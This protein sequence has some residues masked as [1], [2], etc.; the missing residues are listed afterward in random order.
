MS[1]GIDH[2]R[3]IMDEQ[4][5]PQ[6]FLEVGAS[7]VIADKNGEAAHRVAEGLAPEDRR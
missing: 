2:G 5:Y 1:G 3:C 6:L 4:G 7:V